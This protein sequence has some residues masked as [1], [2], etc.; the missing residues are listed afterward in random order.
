MLVVP[1]NEGDPLALVDHAATEN[2][3][4]PSDHLLDARGLDDPVCKKVRCSAVLRRGRAFV[5]SRPRQ[6]CTSAAFNVIID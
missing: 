6:G 3:A 4:V 1:G 5:R 2:F